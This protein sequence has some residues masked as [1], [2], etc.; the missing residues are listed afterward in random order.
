MS[1]YEWP[2]YWGGLILWPKYSVQEEHRLCGL[3]TRPWFQGSHRGKCY[4]SSNNTFTLIFLVHLYT[5]NKMDWIYSTHFSSF[6]VSHFLYIHIPK[7]FQISLKPYN[8]LCCSSR[9]K[10]FRIFSVCK[11]RLTYTTFNRAAFYSQCCRKHM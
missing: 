1:G 5:V 6:L 7:S 2:E 8:S 4:S 3:T 9:A 10:D 11:W